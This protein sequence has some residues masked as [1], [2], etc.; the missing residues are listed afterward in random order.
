[1]ELLET[2]E[3]RDIPR[4]EDQWIYHLLD[5]YLLPKELRGDGIYAVGRKTGPLRKRYP[6]WLYE[7]GE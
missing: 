2:G 4:P 1:M 5:R 7:G 3:F 6:A